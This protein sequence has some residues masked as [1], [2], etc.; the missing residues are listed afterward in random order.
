MPLGHIVGFPETAGSGF[1]S[2]CNLDAQHTA[3][4]GWTFSPAKPSAAVLLWDS[5]VLRMALDMTFR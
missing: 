5:Q 4:P 1:V 2:F 3:S